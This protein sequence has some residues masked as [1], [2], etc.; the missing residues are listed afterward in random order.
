MKYK[1]A[2]TQQIK[3]SDTLEGVFDSLVEVQQFIDTVMA[4]FEKISISIDVINESE[5]SEDAEG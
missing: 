3:Y 5:E 1:V 2:V 4:H